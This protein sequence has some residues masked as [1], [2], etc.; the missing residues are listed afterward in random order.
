MTR[1]VA[2]RKPAS[3]SSAY[4]R[5][6]IACPATRTLGL[7]DVQRLA[8]GDPQLVGHQVAPRDRLGDRVLDLQPGIHLEEVE[9]AR[10]VEQEFDR[11]GALVADGR[12]PRS[13]QP[14][15]I[16]SRSA[17]IDGR[18]RRLLDD[19]LVPSLGGAVALAQVN[20]VPVPVE[21]DLDLYVARTV[22]QPFQDQALVAEGAGRLATGGRQGIG[23]VGRVADDV[24][25]L[26][27][28]AGRWLDQQR[29]P[30]RAAAASRVASSCAWPS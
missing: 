2:G 17:G 12:A 13:A 28:P 22:E 18:R 26:P 9:V 6:S 24:H 7:L 11:A 27:A 5:A 1:P 21:Q 3:G 8:R 20:A 29:Q 14:S 19:L 16:R 10:V 23:Q 25:P 4:R 30:M 15:P